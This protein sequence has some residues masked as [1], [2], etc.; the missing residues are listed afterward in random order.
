[1]NCVD[2]VRV[3]YGATVLKVPTE[4]ENAW[5][6]PGLRGPYADGSQQVHFVDPNQFIT[7]ITA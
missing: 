5:S 7:S 1:M 2:Y 4:L 6:Y 3:I